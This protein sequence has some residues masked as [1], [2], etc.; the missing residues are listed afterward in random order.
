ML[1]VAP[2]WPLAG[3][4]DRSEER[5]EN[6]R[7]GKKRQKMNIER[8]MGWKGGKKGE[9]W[10]EKRRKEGKGKGR[11]NKRRPL[12]SCAPEPLKN[13]VE[14]RKWTTFAAVFFSRNKTAFAATSCV[15][16]A[17]NGAKY[18]CGRGSVRTQM[19]GAYCYLNLW[20]KVRTQL[21]W[22]GK[23]Y[24]SRMQNFFT[25]KMI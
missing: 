15:S 17:L 13:H 19:W 2:C 23:F 4:G 9:R 6:E 11:E 1:F 3:S 8:E 10:K 12:T 16:W 22:C 5:W 21:R 25:I 14:F 7:E 20:S 24:Y 18:V